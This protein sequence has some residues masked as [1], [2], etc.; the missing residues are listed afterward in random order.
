MYFCFFQGA[1]V[2]LYGDNDW[3][4]ATVKEIKGK[5][6]TLESDYGK[7]F[8]IILFGVLWFKAF[9]KV[10]SFFPYINLLNSVDDNTVCR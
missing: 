8:V 2:W 3:V 4:P 10:F 5:E 7:V 9:L 6:V 1:K